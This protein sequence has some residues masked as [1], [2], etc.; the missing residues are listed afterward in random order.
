MIRQDSEKIFYSYDFDAEKSK[1]LFSPHKLP[2]PNIFQ[3]TVFKKHYGM[4][5]DQRQQFG[6][7]F[8]QLFL[9]LTTMTDRRLSQRKN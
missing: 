7:D 9:I 8:S 6:N 1:I 4:L 2:I 5:I 3:G